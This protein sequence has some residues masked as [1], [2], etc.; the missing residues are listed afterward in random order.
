LLY[1]LLWNLSTIKDT[2][3]KMPEQFTWL[4]SLLQVRQH[5]DMFAPRPPKFSGWY[6]IPGSLRNGAQIDPFQDG[7]AVT[8]EKPALAPM[9]YKNQRWRKYLR[10]IFKEKNRMHRGYFAQYL[11]REWNT[12]HEENQQLVEVEIYFMRKDTP[13]QPQVV[14]PQRVLLW[15]HSCFHTPP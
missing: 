4:G 2:P 9:T 8:W 5:W 7:K 13:P 11:C 10:N 12:R 3:V 14:A 1:V 6:V 15:K